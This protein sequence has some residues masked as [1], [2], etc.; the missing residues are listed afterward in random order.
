MLGRLLKVGGGS[1]RCKEDVRKVGDGF[2]PLV[3]NVYMR[4]GLKDVAENRYGLQ[5]RCE[6]YNRTIDSCL[7]SWFT[8]FSPAAS[9]HFTHQD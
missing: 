3:K 6:A 2:M 4:R 7:T 8:R 9:M 5:K 1:I